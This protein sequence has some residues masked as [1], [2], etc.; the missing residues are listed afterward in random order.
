[1]VLIVTCPYCGV[2]TIEGARGCPHASFDDDGVL[3]FLPPGVTGTLPPVAGVSLRRARRG[4]LDYAVVDVTFAG[5]V[6]AEVIT[7]PADNAYHHSVTASGL[8]ECYEACPGVSFVRDVP[9]APGSLEAVCHEMDAT[10]T[11][12]HVALTRAGIPEVVYPPEYDK[13]CGRALPLEERVERLAAQVRAGASVDTPPPWSPIRCAVCGTADEVYQFPTD[14]GGAGAPCV[15]LGCMEAAV[16]CAEV[17]PGAVSPGPSLSFLG[18][19]EALINRFSLENG[20]DTPDFVLAEYLQASLAAFDAA[21]R[22]RE[23]WSGM[24]VS[25]CDR[26]LDVEALT[27]IMVGRAPGADAPVWS[28]DPCTV[29]G[30][31]EDVEE[32]G[33]VGSPDVDGGRWSPVRLCAPCRRNGDVPPVPPCDRCHGVEDVQLLEMKYDGAGPRRL[34]AGCRAVLGPPYPAASARNVPD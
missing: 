32:Q 17:V 14:R 16:P 10:L 25:V 2:R 19:L 13:L 4:S 3:S 8:L 31:F 1:M 27:R 28:P 24:A 18:E 7:E 29:C 12:V 21:V 6:V 23:R 15:C 22:A 30:G 26:S 5:G 11:K 9:P 34:C 20:S 33:A